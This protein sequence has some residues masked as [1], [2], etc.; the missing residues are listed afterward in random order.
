MLTD[1]GSIVLKPDQRTVGEYFLSGKRVWVAGHRGMAGSAVVRR[2]VSEPIGEL[3]TATH[4]E[5]DLRDQ[6]ATHAFVG[7]TRPDAVILA[8]GKV[9]G[10]R[11]NQTA[12]GEFL[13]D[14][15]MI[16][17]NVLEAA[18]VNEVERT[19][20]L[21][22]SCI[23]P[24]EAAQPMAEDA[25]LTGPL[26]ETNEGYAVAKIA[27]LEMAKMY[28]RQ[29]GM[30]T[31]SVMPSNLY[32]TNDDFDLETSHVLGALLRKTHEAMLGGAPTVAIWGSGA[33]RR[34]F[35][36][37]DDLADAS[38]FVLQHYNGEAHLNVGTGTDVSINELAELIAK[39]V[40]WDGE[41]VHDTSMPDGTARK[42]LDVSKLTELGWSASIGLE[43]GIRST[44]EWYLQNVA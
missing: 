7:D 3:I 33:P 8:A 42:L 30:D 26:D 17:A 10:I 32:G 36:H 21:G 22:S 44:Y 41:F 40:G 25:F 13:Y 34:E 4:E 12:P 28:R 38:V 14:N 35:L 27:A 29:Y 20:N 39:I 23:Y 6:D 24:K 43:T 2:L 18:R 31:I 5:L 1:A 16:A 11:V 19:V 9:G 15:L 37:V